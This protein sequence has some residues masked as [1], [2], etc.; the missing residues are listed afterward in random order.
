MKETQPIQKDE[1]QNV[2][3]KEVK[4]TKQHVGSLL[5]GDGHKVFEFNKSTCEL[6]E[7]SPEQKDV[8]YVAAKK[9]LLAGAK[10]VDAKENCFYFSSLNM[11]NAVKKI[12]KWFPKVTVIQVLE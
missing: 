10:R 8:D 3:Q 7:V 9:G 11:K 2:R 6:Q 5:P 4:R 12:I 1:V